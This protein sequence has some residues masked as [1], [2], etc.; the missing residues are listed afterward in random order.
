MDAV[1]EGNGPKIV[2][3]FEALYGGSPTPDRLYRAAVDALR[4]H[5]QDQAEKLFEEGRAM[6]RWAE[7]P[8]ELQVFVPFS[9]DVVREELVHVT[10][11]PRRRV[12]L[13]HASP[14]EMT[15]LDGNVA[16]I[17]I[18]D[19]DRRWTV[20]RNRDAAVEVATRRNF[21]N[22]MQDVMMYRDQYTPA[23]FA[24]QKALVARTSKEYAEE[25]LGEALGISPRR[26]GE[27]TVS[28]FYFFDQGNPWAV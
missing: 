7:L 9:P 4:I 2:P 23:Q 24:Q 22:T 10:G 25:H 26:N 13:L 14:S 8:L 19:D 18:G 28:G 16:G 21:R 6:D 12:K 1:E 3:L 17:G 20:F 15:F 11:L 5:R 27:R